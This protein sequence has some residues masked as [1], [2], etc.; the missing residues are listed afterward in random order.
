MFKI[1]IKNWKQFQHYN[2]RNPPWIRLYRSL[3][4]DYEFA[5]LPDASR[6]LA[7]CIWLLASEYPDGE[8]TAS[9]AAIAFR[10]H[11]SEAKLESALKPLIDNGFII[12]ASTMLARRYQDATPET[13]TETETD[14]ELDLRKSNSRALSRTGCGEEFEN[15]WK[16]YP[17]RDGANPKQPAWKAFLAAVKA[18]TD[19]LAIVAGAKAYAADPSTKVA[20]PYVAQAVTW[21]HQHRWEDFARAAADNHQH[22]AEEEAE[23][24]SRKVYWLNRLAEEERGKRA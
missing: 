8:I 1:T 9:R 14:T 16:S 13:E 21:L 4:D 22:K 10:L 12:D 11:I 6:A 24:E 15:F 3:I 17:K 5:C 18:G 20:T 2:K 23:N 7:P 19:P